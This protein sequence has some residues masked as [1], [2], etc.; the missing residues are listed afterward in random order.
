MVVVRFITDGAPR[1]GADVLK[2][3]L[4]DL[5]IHQIRHGDPQLGF[6]FHGALDGEHGAFVAGPVAAG[7]AVVDIP[8]Q[9]AVETTVSLRCAVEDHAEATVDDF[10]PANAA[11]VVDAHPGGTTETVADDVLHFCTAMSAVNDE[12]S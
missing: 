3:I 9:H 7:D 2:Q 11:A 5:V 8:V 1:W 12:P 6:A 4:Q 10:A